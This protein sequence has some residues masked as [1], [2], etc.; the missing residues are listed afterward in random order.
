MNK[1]LIG[2]ISIAFVACNGN[3]DASSSEE[4]A[5]TNLSGVENVNGNIPDTSNAMTVDGSSQAGDTKIDTLVK[6]SLNRQ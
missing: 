6:D 2:L 1:L 3:S 4:A 5:P